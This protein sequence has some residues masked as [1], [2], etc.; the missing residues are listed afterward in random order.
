LADG[1]F[2]LIP[3]FI[4]TFF[5]N[6]SGYPVNFE[7]YIKLRKD[8]AELTFWQRV[9]TLFIVKNSLPLRP[10]LHYL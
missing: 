5:G 9:H 3:G 6:K 4:L 2:F 10:E 1:G 8:G 7:G